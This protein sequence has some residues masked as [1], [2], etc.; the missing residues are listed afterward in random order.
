ML[1][2]KFA[3]RQ[4]WRHPVGSLVQTCG[5][6][7]LLSHRFLTWITTRCSGCWI[8]LGIQWTSIN[9]ITGKFIN[10]NL[11]YPDHAQIVHA[12]TACS[13]KHFFRNTCI[14]DC[15]SVIWADCKTNWYG[16]MPHLTSN[17]I[18]VSFCGRLNSSSWGKLSTWWTFQLV[19]AVLGGLLS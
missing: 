14:S 6:T 17:V 1:W 8:T 2:K 4:I 16:F 3:I 13:L 18:A 7:W 12:I 9:F 19:N 5:S 11:L 10:E 15:I